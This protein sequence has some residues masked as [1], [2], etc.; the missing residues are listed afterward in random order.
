[1]AP[2]NVPINDQSDAATA[3]QQA[4]KTPNASAIDIYNRSKLFLA[5]MVIHRFRDPSVCPAGPNLS[6]RDQ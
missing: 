5:W 3:L 6:A 2:I 4:K 1:M